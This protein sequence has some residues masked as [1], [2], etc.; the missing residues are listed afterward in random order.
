MTRLIVRGADIMVKLLIAR[1]KGI[2]KDF[3]LFMIVGVFLGVATSV[4]N[5]TLNNFLL[6]KFHLSIT[7]RSNMEILRELPGFLVFLVTGFMFALG[8]IRIAVIA[9]IC[10]AVGMFALGI[11]P[12]NY[13][14]MLIF[15]FI[16]SMGLHVY[17]PL[18][19]SIGMSF[20]NDTNMGRKLG[21]VNAAN[22]AALLLS[23]AALWFLFQFFKISY[24]ITFTIGTVALL[25]A[26]LFLILM[27]PRQTSKLKTRFVFKKEYI[28]YYWLSLLFGARKQILLTFAPWVL[29]KVFKQAVTTMTLLVFIIAFL[30]IFIKPFVGYL[31]DKIGEKFVLGSEAFLFFFVCLG[32]A[33]ASNLLPINGAI[34]LTCIC[35]IM[36][37]SL[38]AVTIARATYMKKIAV[39]EEDVSPTLAT[40]TSIDHIM[41]MFLPTLGGIVWI[42]F[43]Y[44]YVFIGGAILAFINFFSTRYIKIKPRESILLEDI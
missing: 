27:N 29:V 39:K 16:Y 30:G 10:A 42:T 2:E 32:Y 36:D 21:R 3:L 11:I 31:I 24:T 6:E 34:I 18:A 28:L 20:A 9:N 43:G 4:D 23:S 14:I 8:D 12:A 38:N 37:Q 33:F 44:K 5:S 40:G 17:M 26:A 25:F 19:N 22:T 1:I 41:S 7:Q 15:M 13:A 35:Y